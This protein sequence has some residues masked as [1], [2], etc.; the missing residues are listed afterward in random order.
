MKRRSLL[1]SSG[2][3]ALTALLAGCSNRR[4]ALR[5]LFLADSVPPQLLK[6]FRNVLTQ[7]IPLNFVPRPQ[8]AGLFEQLENWQTAESPPRNTA[9]LV[10][11]GDAW[12]TEAI[13][14]NLIQPLDVAALSN[15]ERIPKPWQ[16]LVKRDRQGALSVDGQVWGAPY[17]WGSVAIAFRKDKLEPLGW[18]PQDWADLW[19]PELNGLISLPDSARTVLG[20]VLKKLGR[21][22]N[23]ADLT[24]VPQ[25]TEELAALDRQTKFYSSTAYLQPL[26]IED[27]WAAVGW[28]TD[29]L[30]LMQGDPRIGAVVPASG[31]MLFSDLWVRPVQPT[32]TDTDGVSGA[33]AALAQWIDF[34]WQPEAATRLSLQTAAVS[35]IFALDPTALPAG[36]GNRTVLLPPDAVLQKSEFL[37]PLSPTSAAQFR[38][39]WS[40]LRLSASAGP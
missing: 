27:T 15:W 5:V 18:Q 12:L 31:T 4:E 22:V 26:L 32:A 10:T 1:I 36:L 9:D 8:L 25:L 24:T 35:P 23:E 17:R 28:T 2:T 30:P 21:S 6:A 38:Q 13:Q 19:R 37:L 11:L 16:D 7:S 33:E 40:A 20:L 29:I 14:Q 34:C 3:L 39:A